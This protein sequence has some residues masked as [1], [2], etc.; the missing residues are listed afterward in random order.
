VNLNRERGLLS[1][2]LSSTSIVEEREIGHLI[3][4]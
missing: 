2:T 4:K 1:P 3:K